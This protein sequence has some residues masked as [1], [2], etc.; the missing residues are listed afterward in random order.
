MDGAPT[1]FETG[2]EPA[3]SDWIDTLRAKQP[4]AEWHS[5]HQPSLLVLLEH[6]QKAEVSTSHNSLDQFELL[7]VEDMK[8]TN[9]RAT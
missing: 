9:A 6:L 8:R 5:S 4:V 3:R 7:L 1:S 2:L